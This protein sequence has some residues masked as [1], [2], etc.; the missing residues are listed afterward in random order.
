MKDLILKANEIIE[1]ILQFGTCQRDSKGAISYKIEEGLK[2]YNK[3]VKKDCKLLMATV[4]GGIELL[5]Y[6]PESNMQIN[7]EDSFLSSPSK[8]VQP[9]QIKSSSPVKN[10]R[11]SISYKKTLE[12]DVKQ[13][14]ILKLIDDIKI[15]VFNEELPSVHDAV[16]EPKIMKVF[17]D[18]SFAPF[19][20][21]I[22]CHHKNKIGSDFFQVESSE[23]EGGCDM[24]ALEKIK[25]NV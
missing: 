24:T 20:N 25:F 7:I 1:K 4:F 17:Q 3:M 14:D 6:I 16:K 12:D 8:Y 21:Q 11:N 15:D 2:E 23:D 13:I 22:E 9:M 18:A 5:I 10:R 19:I